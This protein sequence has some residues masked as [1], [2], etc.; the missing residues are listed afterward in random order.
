MDFLLHLFFLLNDDCALVEVDDVAV[1]GVQAE[2]LVELVLAHGEKDV[3]LVLRELRIDIAAAG[4]AC[5]AHLLE[6]L[7][8]AIEAVENAAVHIVHIGTLIGEARY[9]HTALGQHS[10]QAIEGLGDG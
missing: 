2:Q 5:D 1:L 6:Q 9:D 7:A 10:S 4:H 3:L 8:L